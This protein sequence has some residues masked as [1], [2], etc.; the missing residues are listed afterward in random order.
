MA[1]CHRAMV[2]RAKGRRPQ[3]RPG[4]EGDDSDPGLATQRDR[5]PT[6]T[7]DQEVL[8]KSAWVASVQKMGGAQGP[9]C[10]KFRGPKDP[11]VAAPLATASPSRQLLACGGRAA[12]ED[13]PAHLLRP[14]PLRLRPLLAVLGYERQALALI[15]SVVISQS[16]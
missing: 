8:S 6:G 14:C 5:G 10:S 12:W 9:Q 1:S 4:E 13:R 11:G 3:N 15:V 2:E 7:R 16:V